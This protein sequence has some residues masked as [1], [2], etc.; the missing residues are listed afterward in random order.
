LLVT[1]WQS[2]KIIGIEV[3]TETDVVGPSAEVVVKAAYLE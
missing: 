2:Q 3:I 1:I